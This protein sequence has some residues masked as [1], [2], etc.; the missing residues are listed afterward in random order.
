MYVFMNDALNVFYTISAISS[1]LNSENKIPIM[2]WAKSVLRWE[3]NR[4]E[5]GTMK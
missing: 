4:D 5:T 3:L 2:E 1:D